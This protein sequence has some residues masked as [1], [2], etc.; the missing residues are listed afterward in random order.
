[1]VGQRP[2]LEMDRTKNGQVPRTTGQNA[3]ESKSIIVNVTPILDQPTQK[4]HD[5]L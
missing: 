3:L 4:P 5:L 1:M 2:Q